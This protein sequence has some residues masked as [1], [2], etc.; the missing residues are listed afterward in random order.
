MKVRDLPNIAVNLL[1]FDTFY[2]RRESIIIINHSFFLGF[3]LFVILTVTFFSEQSILKILYAIGWGVPL[4]LVII[5][6]VLRAAIEE[7]YKGLK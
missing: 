5:Y 3:Y 7:S 6:V 1:L 4:V 2:N